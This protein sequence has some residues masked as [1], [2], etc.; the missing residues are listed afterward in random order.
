MRNP[1][2]LG[3]G[4]YVHFNDYDDLIVTANHHEPEQATEIVAISERD[5]DRLVNYIERN[6]RHNK[7]HV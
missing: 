6:R 7:G 3:D 2:H 5:L 4:A 1:E